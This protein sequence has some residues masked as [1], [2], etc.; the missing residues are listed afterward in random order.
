M[1]HVF[2]LAV[3]EKF[4]FGK[5]FMHWIEVILK[6]QESCV[7][8]GGS[9]TGYFS[10]YRGA[11]QGD[12]ISAYMFILI[13][14]ILFISIRNNEN[15]EGLSIFNNT[16]KLFAYADDTTFFLKNKDSVEFL[17]QTFKTFSMFSGLKPNASKCEICGIGVKRGE[18]VALCGMKS[19]DLTL[20]SI[21]ILGNELSRNYNKY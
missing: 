15:I 19:T 11:R 5:S 9:T 21:K 17:L 1:D 6:N 14:E 18:K 7:M 10:L 12:P 20:E 16:Y 8:N 4:G 3:L 2:L 13:Q